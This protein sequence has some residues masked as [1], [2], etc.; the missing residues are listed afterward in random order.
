MEKILFSFYFY[1]IFH[2]NSLHTIAAAAVATAAVP[3]FQRAPLLRTSFVIATDNNN[4]GMKQK[5]NNTKPAPHHHSMNS[6]VNLETG[7]HFRPPS[8]F[9]DSREFSDTECD[10]DRALDLEVQQVMENND[11]RKIER[12]E[13]TSLLAR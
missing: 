5:K 11:M 8:G 3:T 9:T 2:A 12:D 4:N 1:F 13:L 7:I 10:R 6:E